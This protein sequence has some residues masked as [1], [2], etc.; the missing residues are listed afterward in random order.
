MVAI[1][2]TNSA[3]P[4]LQASVS[5]ARLEQAR[6]DADQAESNAERLRSQADAAESEAQNGHNRVRELTSR[7]QQTDPTYKPKIQDAAPEVS[8]KEQ[9]LLV[10]AFKA[11]GATHTT[12]ASALKSS[13]DAPPVV[14]T[15]GQAIGR[16]VNV[17]A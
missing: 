7:S 13:Q 5:K 15:Q 14:N 3:T 10:E 4:S 6:R 16:I 12:H 17:T 11:T 2:A 9:E 1:T 8:A